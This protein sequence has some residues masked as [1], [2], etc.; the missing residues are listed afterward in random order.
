MQAR[1]L[2]YT[3]TSCGS[4][5]MPSDVDRDPLPVHLDPVTGEIC[6]GRIG[7]VMLLPRPDT[8]E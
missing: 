4:T 3:C 1:D 2:T 6:P 5:S 8:E 7:T